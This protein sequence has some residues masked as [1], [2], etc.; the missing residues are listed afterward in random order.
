MRSKRQEQIVELNEVMKVTQVVKF[1]FDCLIVVQNDAGELYVS[2]KKVCL[3]KHS[4]WE[5]F[6]AIYNMTM[7]DSCHMLFVADGTN[8]LIAVDVKTGD[9]VWNYTEEDLKFPSGVCNGGNGDLFFV[10]TG[11]SESHTYFRKWS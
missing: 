10:R 1:D 11:F 9:W 4:K 7:S 8:G 5:L 6:S 2:D 3:H